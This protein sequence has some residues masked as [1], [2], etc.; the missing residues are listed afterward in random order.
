MRLTSL[1]GREATGLNGPAWLNDS[2]ALELLPWPTPP[3][4]GFSCSEAAAAAASTSSPV[5]SR[6][7][8][9]VNVGMD[10]R[11]GS[12]LTSDPYNGGPMYHIRKGELTRRMRSQLQISLPLLFTTFT[13]G[14]PLTAGLS[15]ALTSMPAATR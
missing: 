4:W 8:P 6:G 7:L 13:L 11:T 2:S 15:V 10:S 3:G 12:L 14:L 9:D 1:V 5:E